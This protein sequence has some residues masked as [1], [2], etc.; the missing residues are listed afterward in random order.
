MLGEG[1]DQRQPGS[2][3][4]NALSLEADGLTTPGSVLAAIETALAAG[5]TK[6]AD[7]LI[8]A[9]RG[10]QRRAKA[11]SDLLEAAVESGER[12][13]P[14]PFFDPETGEG[15]M[16]MEWIQNASDEE[17][18]TYIWRVSGETLTDRI[19]KDGK[20]ERSGMA[21]FY[22]LTGCSGAGKS[23]TLDAL[24]DRGQL[25]LSE[26][27]RRIVR[28][29]LALDG[30]ALPWVNPERFASQAFW[31]SAT[32]MANTMTA[33]PG[34]VPVFCDRGLVDAALALERLGLEPAEEKLANFPR[35]EAPVFLFHPWRDLFATDRER[36]HSF[37]EACA[38]F[39]AIAAALPKL[40]YTP[41]EVPQ[42]TVEARLEFILDRVCSD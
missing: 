16:T 25:T 18:R 2:G 12:E 38:E 7:R 42:D 32:E 14:I 28:D 24:A 34:E 13:P 22:L 26:P 15:K 41:V 40:G 39:D 6:Q 30:E 37:D 5:D 35:Y 11:L 19:Y 17:L 4:P 33:H 21:Q 1:L 29:E 20:L 8:A 31:M 3:R 36:R 23:T 27:G 9:W 10:E